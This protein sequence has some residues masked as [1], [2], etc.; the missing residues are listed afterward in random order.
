M[1]ARAVAGSVARFPIIRNV[2][3]TLADTEYSTTL[4]EN[5]KGFIIHT[6]DETEFRVSYEAGHVATP[7]APY[8]TVPATKAYG[9]G[10]I[11]IYTYGGALLTLYFA[12][13]GA[14]K[15]IEIIYWT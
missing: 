5:T 13:A 7:T 10:D 3:M 8:F 15:V 6:R 9:E 2:T 14:G 1:S 11:S 12:S 4:P